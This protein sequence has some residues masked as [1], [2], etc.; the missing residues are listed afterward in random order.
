MSHRFHGS[1]QI[2]LTWAVRFTQTFTFYTNSCPTDFRDDHR[3]FDLFGQ[4]YADY[5]R[6]YAVPLIGDR[7]L[8]EHRFLF[9]SQFLLHDIQ[10]L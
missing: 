8:K 7:N 1:T 6:T 4:I 10:N 3:F 9:P 5:L 2:F